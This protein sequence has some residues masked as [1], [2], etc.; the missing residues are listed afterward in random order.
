MAGLV[1]VGLD[2]SASAALAADYA[3]DDAVRRGAT[4]K[5]VHVRDP[6]SGDLA[7]RGLDNLTAAA[8]RHGEDI[9]AAAKERAR[10]RVPD[11]D[12]VTRMV[13][14]SIVEQLKSESAEADCLVV[15]SRGMGGFAGLLLGSVGLGVAG[16]VPGPIVV[17][18]QM[19]P[20]S[21][22]E[23]V[24]GY[25]GSDHSEAALEYAFGEAR[26]RGA[27]LKVI[28]TWQELIFSPY[29]IGYSQLL[30][31]VFNDRVADVHDRL[32]SWRERN[33]D[34]KVEE[35]FLTG[36]PIPTLNE[37]SRLADLVVVGSRGMGAFGSAVLGSVSHG[38]LHGA[39]C[40][41]AVVRPYQEE[42]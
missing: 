41:V 25:D 27:G 9:L 22:G 5:I 12:V 6:W 36:H 42:R 39:S 34:V 7:L 1:V 17:V 31:G 2:G 26:R 21:Y 38:V 8:T 13:T 30:Q 10:E 37:A 23:I 24:V 40:P 14:G 15:G 29:A 3:V 19:A 18:R 4:L 35:S 11:L 28:Y 32:T 20:V 33:P 16:H